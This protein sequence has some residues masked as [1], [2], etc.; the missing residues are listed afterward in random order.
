MKRRNFLRAA[1][2][3]SVASVAAP[4]IAQGIRELRMATAWPK[5]FPGVGA[6][7]ERLA[8]N[9]EAMSGGKLRIKVFA[10]GELVPA[11]EAFDAV[12]RG[13]ADMYHGV[14]YYW[15]GK[16]KAFNF[17]GA[18]P[19][20]LT[21]LETFSWLEFGGGQALWD[22]LNAPFNVKA[23]TAGTGGQQ[24][25]G[26]YRNEMKSIEDFK[27]LKIRIPGLGGEV[28]RRIGAAPVAL[29]PGEIFP[30]LQSGAID[31]AEWISPW[32]DLAFGFHK[33]LKNYYFPGFQEAC[34]PI[35]L[36]INTKVWD[37]LPADHK[38]IVHVAS[39]AEGE[40]M[41]AEF[42]INNA[43]ALETL[44]GQNGVVMRAFPDEVLKQF[45][46]ASREAAAELAGVSPL[47]RKIHDSYMNFRK[48]AMTWSN[49]GE[50]PYLRARRLFV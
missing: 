11:F 30:A 29:P 43:R 48:Q 23:F 22:E 15:V 14:P 27:G 2:A 40:L 20:G 8:R 24:M 21:Q 12:S 17:F 26:W 35:D 18:V 16:D 4:A 7:A 39:Q 45:A 9:I 32:A 49:V 44:V 19:F 13:A 47:A 10:A 50:E 1:G 28:M 37:S 42:N 5:G 46:T 31:A 25:G 38:S 34:A 3:V 36:G 33:V 6:G 41:V